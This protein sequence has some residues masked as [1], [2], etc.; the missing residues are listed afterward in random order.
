[1]RSHDQDAPQIA[2]ALLGDG[3]R[4][5]ACHR[6]SFARNQADEGGQ[7]A[8]RLERLGIG[9]GCGKCGCPDDAD[10]GDGLQPST[11]RA[12]AVLGMQALVEGVD[13][14]LQGGDLACQQLQARARILWQ[15]LIRGIGDDRQQQR[16]DLRLPVA[17]TSPNSAMC[18][19]SALMVCVRCRSRRSRT[20]CCISRPCCSGVL[21]RHKAH[22]RPAHRLADRRRVRRIGLV[23]LHIGLHV[24]RWHQPNV[25]TEL[26]ELARPVMRPRAR[27]HAQP[28]TAA[29]WRRWRAPGRAAIA[30]STPP[31]P[32]H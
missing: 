4:G 1:M 18:A 15:A 5:A 19:R 6:S 13:L 3:T 16:R 9:D 25:V 12:L 11:G 29:A 17:A 30:S 28:G 23:A 2:V 32:R 10:A 26:P 24:P 7:I 21:T 8:P 22:R 20:R 14:R 31:S 27:F